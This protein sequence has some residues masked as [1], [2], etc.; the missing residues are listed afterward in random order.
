MEVPRKKVDAFIVLPSHGKALVIN[1]CLDN[2]YGVLKEIGITFELCVVIDG[3]FD[4]TR[5]VISS[6]PRNHLAIVVLEENKGKGFAQR[7]GATMAEAE[8]LIFFDADNDINPEIFRN[9]ISIMQEQ[10]DVVMVAADKLHQESLIKYPTSR[11]ILSMAFRWIVRI[12]FSVKIRDSQTGFKALRLDS[13]L[14][15]L[16]SCKENGF[17]F[18]LELMI[19]LLKSSKKIAYIPVAISHNYGSTIHLFTI[20]EIFYDLIK[21]RFIRFRTGY[22]I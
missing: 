8:I 13:C 1:E 18:E 3:D 2:L 4:G 16:E 14:D 19:R 22:L 9:A 7:V 21:L 11:S 6:I 17:L 20:F 10:S 12:L 15:E 5:H